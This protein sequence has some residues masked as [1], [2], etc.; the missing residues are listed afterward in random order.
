[1]LLGMTVEGESVKDGTAIQIIG[2][3]TARVF[4]FF[5]LRTFQVLLSQ[6]DP[7]TFPML[8]M[9]KVYAVQL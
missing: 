1:M 8:R 7:S 3:N 5:I 4:I 9:L 2:N 6:A